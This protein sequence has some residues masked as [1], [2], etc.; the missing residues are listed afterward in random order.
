MS[1]SFLDGRGHSFKMCFMVVRRYHA[2][3][4]KIVL[5]SGLKRSSEWFTRY[6]RS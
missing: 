6:Q 5:E 3:M 2:S 4:F 1:R